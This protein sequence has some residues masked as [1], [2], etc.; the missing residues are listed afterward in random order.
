[1]T[2]LFRILR[3]VGIMAFAM[4][5]AFK[6]SPSFRSPFGSDI[7]LLISLLFIGA[8]VFFRAVRNIVHGHIFDENFL[9]SIASICAFLI[10]ER[11]EALAILLFYYLGELLQDFA[12]DKSR[13]SISALMDTR[14]DHANLRA[15]ETVQQV[16]PASVKVGEL[17]DVRPGERVPLDGVVHNG[18]SMLDMSALTGESALKRV[19]A[20]D[21]VLSGSLNRRGL[22][23]LRVTKPFSESTVSKILELVEHAAE[24]KSHT[25]RFITTFARYYTPA[26]VACA[27]LLFAVPVLLLGYDFD[28][29]L[30]R[31]LVF[32]VVSCP[33]ALVISVPVSYFVGIGEA[34]RA[35]VLVKGA[36]YLD[37]L[38]KVG[39]AVF[40]KTGTLTKG[41]FKLQEV[42]GYDGWNREMLLDIV[43]VAESA[44]THPIAGSIR[45]AVSL[46]PDIKRMTKCEE[47]GGLGIK[48][49]VDSKVVLV[50]SSKLLKSENVVHKE[51]YRLGT[52][53]YIAID[54]V[55]VGYLLISDE[56]K[57]DSA[58]A[59]EQL[60]AQG[61]NEIAMLTGDNE[62]SGRHV[63]SQLGIAHCFAALLPNEKAEKIEELRQ[64]LPKGT[65][66]LFV[67]DGINDAPALAVSDVGIAM[68]V[69]GSDAAIEAADV[70]LMTDEPMK[71]PQVIYIAKS[72]RNVAKQNI[73]LSLTVKG[74]ILVLGALGY[75][76]IW[77]AVL[78]DVG[79]TVLA[80]L[81]A[82]RKR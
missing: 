13:H 65:K 49:V 34:S 37:A 76:G 11:F 14:P 62:M 70:V 52:I 54:G 18:S 29:W 22:I 59:I 81:N 23:T 16:P 8:E 50:G 6:L 20:N 24:N 45:D 30:N 42:H 46:P 78:G 71:L 7:L 61:I 15:G 53:A 40:D 72:T 2:R 64:G 43:S 27:T 21:E 41:T 5:L 38:A 32:L 57:E 31:A 19:E 68:G 55:F 47:L 51:T 36:N 63:A 67:G 74:A 33:C 10:G 66:I 9:M 44:S 73:V 56:L 26:V 25:E 58:Q 4:A 77:T 1:M 60:K 3:S 28:E 79:V 69:L 80:V 75:A 17:I 35:G 12:L 39:V 82:M 48:A